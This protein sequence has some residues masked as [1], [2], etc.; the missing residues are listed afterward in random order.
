MVTSSLFA[1]DHNRVDLSWMAHFSEVTSISLAF[2]RT[3][4]W[5]QLGWPDTSSVA[6]LTA[7]NLRGV[8]EIE[9][10]ELASSHPDLRQM[11]LE[12]CTF[13]PS[14]LPAEH[15]SNE[16]KLVN[17]ERLRIAN[18]KDPISSNSFVEPVKYLLKS[19]KRSKSLSWFVPIG[20]A[21]AREIFDRDVCE[22]LKKSGVECVQLESR[23][24]ASGC[25]ELMLLSLASKN[26]VYLSITGNFSEKDIARLEKLVTNTTFHG[27]N[28][29]RCF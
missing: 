27:S 7:L 23:N 12:D 18:Q 3:T 9:V 21:N 10:V 24:L 20:D 1:D 17:L 4:Q 13:S 28:F 16:P 25:V 11:S 22:K 6:A 8:E 2:M 29:A 15:H 5:R 26:D 14:T 19:S